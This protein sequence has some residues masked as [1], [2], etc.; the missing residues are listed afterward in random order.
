[1][2][3]WL[4]LQDTCGVHNLHGLPGV[5][6]G[7]SSAIAASV[8]GGIVSYDDR[9]VWRVCV[10]VCVCVWN[11]RVRGLIS[12][13]AFLLSS[14]LISLSLQSLF[15]IPSTCHQ[16]RDPPDNTAEVARDRARGG[17]PCW[18]TSRLPACPPHRHPRCLRTWRAAH[19]CMQLHY[20]QCN[21]TP[22]IVFKDADSQTS[23]VI[24]RLQY[25]KNG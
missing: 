12:P 5:F 6:S 14:L 20:S 1:M 13:L 7:I 21:Y 15:G 2:D 16:Q 23:S 22:G 9:Y 8:A 11:I 24:V 25:I 10:R 18:Y 17:P 19:R 3:R 4:Y